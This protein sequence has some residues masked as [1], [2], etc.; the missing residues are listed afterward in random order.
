[1]NC[2]WHLSIFRG[3]IAKTGPNFPDGFLLPATRGLMY[4]KEKESN[5][6]TLNE[7]PCLAVY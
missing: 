2:F 6:T 5:K 4:N 1:M 3:L 7:N